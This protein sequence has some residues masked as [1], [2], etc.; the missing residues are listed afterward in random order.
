MT[1]VPF[2][3]KTSEE[4]AAEAIY[5][6]LLQSYLLQKPDVKDLYGLLLSHY[7]E[8][9]QS[10]NILTKN[11][12]IRIKRIQDDVKNN[13]YSLFQG[14]LDFSPGV[15]ESLRKEKS[16]KSHRELCQDIVERRESLLEPL[17]GPLKFISTEH[18]TI[19]GPIDI[20]A[21]NGDTIHIIEVKTKSADHSIV[22]QLMKYYVGMSLKIPIRHFDDVKM[23]ALCPGYDKA[24]YSG[25]GNIGAS[26]MLLKSK[27]LEIKELK[28]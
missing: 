23:M 20:L 24:S 22:G 6:L 3:V 7:Q 21:Q 14:T 16:E 10:L 11:D 5:F 17:L 25:L 2:K 1:D 4:S 28:I 8:Y 19:F 12:L 15:P 26:I 18:P 9:P 27:P 13:Q